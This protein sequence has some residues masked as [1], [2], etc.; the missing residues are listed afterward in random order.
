MSLFR[1]LWRCL[2]IGARRVRS[3]VSMLLCLRLSELVI[4]RYLSDGS[5]RSICFIFLNLGDSFHHFFVSILIFVLIDYLIA[6]EYFVSSHTRASVSS[7]R[8]TSRFVSSPS[9][10]MY[11]RWNALETRERELWSSNGNV[12][13]R[14]SRISSLLWLVL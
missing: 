8:W 4:F 3:W 12:R 2:L 9:W 5:E 6:C 13:G 7:I 14:K 1:I 11:Y 10:A